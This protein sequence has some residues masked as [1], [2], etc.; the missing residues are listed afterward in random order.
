MFEQ[1]SKWVIH[2][3]RNLNATTRLFCLPY[4]G[5]TAHIYHSWPSQ[6][7][8][9]LEVCS[10]QP[11]GRGSRLNEP[12]F[13]NLND[14]INVAADALK[15]FFDR[16]FVLFGHSIGALASFELTRCIRGRYG[17]EPLLLMVS[18]CRAPQI[19]YEGTPFFNFPETQFLAKVERLNGI[20]K[21]VLENAELMQLMSPLLRADFTLDQ[22]YIYKED[23]PLSC[24]IIAFGGLDD[25]IVSRESLEAW[26]QQTTAPFSTKLFSGDHFFINTGR[27]FL[28]EAISVAISTT[29]RR[30]VVSGG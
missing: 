29:V 21:E 10:V 19:P 9:W 18:G 28:L 15:P 26:R 22:T 7:P 24:P 27:Q 8:S 23:P 12:P 16:P 2:P 6:L 20:P 4:G 17:V 14:L 13:T 1:K 25:S 5:G 3:A 11:P 30:N